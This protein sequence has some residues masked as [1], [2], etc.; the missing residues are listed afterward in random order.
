M[1]TNNRRRRHRILAIAA[2]GAVAL[3]VIVVAFAIV[4]WLRQPG[5]IPGPTLFTAGR[6]IAPYGGQFGLQP[7]KQNLAE[8]EYFF[9]DTRDEIKKAVRQ[10]IHYGATVIKLVVDDQAPPFADVLVVPFPCRVP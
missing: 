2:A 1:A 5:E 4:V 9:A 7:D 6:I 3:L 8:P 10:N